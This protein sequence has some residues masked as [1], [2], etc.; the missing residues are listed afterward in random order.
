MRSFATK[1]MV[2]QALLEKQFSTLMQVAKFQFN[3]LI[4]A[5]VW[6]HRGIGRVVMGAAFVEVPREVH[7]YGRVT[8]CAVA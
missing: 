3:T 5:I 8:G 2:S 6:L 4:V 1:P 7:K